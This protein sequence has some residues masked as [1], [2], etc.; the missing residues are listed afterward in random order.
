M[1]SYNSSLKSWKPGK[2]VVWAPSAGTIPEKSLGAG[3]DICPSS[4]IW[5]EEFPFTHSFC[6]GHIL[7]WLDKV[8]HIK[9]GHSALHSPLIQMLI[10]PRSI[11]NRHTQ[12]NIWPH[13]WVP[14]SP[15]KQI[16]K[17]NYPREVHRSSSWTQIYYW[18]LK[19]ET[20]QTGTTKFCSR[21]TPTVVEMRCFPRILYLHGWSFSNSS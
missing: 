8:T 12:S 19:S 4:S 10:S 16:H 6:S 14:Y 7:N 9:G 13:I 2:L 17:I 5:Q 18:S 1:Y 11:L 20:E 15:I 3:K 21:F